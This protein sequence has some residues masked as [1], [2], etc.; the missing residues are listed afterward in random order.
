LKTGAEHEFQIA[1]LLLFFLYITVLFYGMF[2]MRGVL[3]EKQSRVVEIIASSVT[4]TQMMFGKLFGI[5]MVGLTQVGI[6][7]LFTLL[8]TR[9]GAALFGAQAASIPYV[10]ISLLAYFVVYFVLGYFLFSSLYAIIGAI[11]ASEE[12]AQQAQWPVTFLVILPMMIFPA[13]LA[14][15]NGPSSVALSLVPF[16]TPTLMM[17]R[18]ALI[19]PP[20]WQILLSMLIMLAAIAACIWVAAR[21]YKVG[22]LMYGKR[23]TL[24]E[25]GR[26]VRNPG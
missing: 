6:W 15:P 24:S 22:M 17:L 16:L 18:I 5:G 21:I 26:W 12:D 7:A 14:N 10:S 3:E 20:L 19:N 13:V 25:L 8:I 11:V 2:V 23:P 9:G 1:F 4:S